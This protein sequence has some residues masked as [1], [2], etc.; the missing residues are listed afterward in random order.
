MREPRLLKVK[1]GMRKSADEWLLK[2]SA[3]SSMKYGLR[4]L[5]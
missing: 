5:S 3:E 2:M 1:L 4:R